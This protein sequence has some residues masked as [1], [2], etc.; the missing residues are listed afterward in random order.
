MD[1]DYR[2][3]GH[4]EGIKKLSFTATEISANLELEIRTLNTQTLGSCRVFNKP[5]FYI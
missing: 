5:N 2:R 4:F 3:V 1:K